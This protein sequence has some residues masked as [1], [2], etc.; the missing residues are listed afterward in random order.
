LIGSRLAAKLSCS[1]VK[2]KW[3]FLY[4]KKQ[5]VQ[6]VLSEYKSKKRDTFGDS[7]VMA[8]ASVKLITEFK[9]NNSFNQG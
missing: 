9:K 2:K 8:T 5:S 3:I 4:K 1:K 7:G 6:I